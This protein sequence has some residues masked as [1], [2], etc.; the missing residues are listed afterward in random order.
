MLIHS[1]ENTEKFT[2]FANELMQKNPDLNKV[3]F[4]KVV[5]SAQDLYDN[6]EISE[7]SLLFFPYFLDININ[8]I[9]GELMEPVF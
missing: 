5:S 7:E 4:Q 8:F 2:K 9:S 3:F 1:R 6:E